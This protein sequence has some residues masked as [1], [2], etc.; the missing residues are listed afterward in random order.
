LRRAAQEEE[1]VDEI[2]KSAA[3][4]TF[5]AAVSLQAAAINGVVNNGT[6]GKPQAGVH[7]ILM[8]LDQGMVEIGN[9]V[10]GADGSFSIDAPPPAADVPYL[11]RA[12]YQDVAYHGAARDNIKPVNIL[13][14]DK[15]SDRAKVVLA[16]QQVIVEPHQGR[17][18]V[19]EIYTINNQTQPPRT[20]VGSGS[21]KDTFQFSASKGVV[22]DLN[23][24][25]SGPSQLPLRQTANEHPNGVYGLDIPIKPGEM[26]VEVN[27]KLPY[28][29]SF[30]FEK[31]AGKSLLSGTPEVTVIAPLDVVTLAGTSLTLTKQE[32]K[33][34]AAFYVW[35]SPQP[36]KFSIS[37]VLPE[38][39]PAAGGEG[40][41]GGGAAAGGEGGGDANSSEA[42]STVE[43]QN[44]VFQAR[45]KILIV[46][47]A[48]LILGL[49][50]LY[51]QAPLATVPGKQKAQAQQP[52]VLAK[53]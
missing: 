28:E 34:G 45:W 52:P 25:V 7:I 50:N 24:N 36:L 27:Y 18:L 9:A 51:R 1:K 15:T 8:K 47:A 11:V 33:Q 38:G 53:K 23:I 44:F 10:S 4:L 37:G 20:L 21:V 46:L 13:V 43:N 17:M 14:Y 42:L 22:Q 19:S 12:D 2:M 40:G 39:G 49:F 3:F 48:A 35:N 26:K 31:N 5:L 41:Q 6:T 16:G 32:P 29:D 30:A